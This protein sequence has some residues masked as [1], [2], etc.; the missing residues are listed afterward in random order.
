MDS[1]L[2]SQTYVLSTLHAAITVYILMFSAYTHYWALNPM[3]PD[4]PQP[5]G[6]PERTTPVKT[7]SLL[8][9]LIWWLWVVGVFGWAGEV[10]RAWVSPDSPHLM[11]DFD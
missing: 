11:A 9:A 5:P 4:A 3:A 2:H 1:I 8:T 10:V 6:I 7:W